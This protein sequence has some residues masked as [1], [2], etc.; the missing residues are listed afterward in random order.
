MAILKTCFISYLFFEKNK[1]FFKHCSDE[2]A[3]TLPH[4]QLWSL[5]QP[6]GEIIKHQGEN[7]R[8]GPLQEHEV[9]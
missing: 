3:L 2:P 7:L 6:P 4:T 5:P 8:L 1:A 9:T